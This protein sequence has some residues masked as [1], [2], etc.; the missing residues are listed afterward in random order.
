M[1]PSAAHLAKH[2]P[3]VPCQ[4]D[5][6]ALDGTLYRGVGPGMPRGQARALLTGDRFVGLE[7][8]TFREAQARWLDCLV[9][10]LGAIEPLSMHEATLDL[11]GH[12]RPEEIVLQVLRSVG[13]VEPRIQSSVAGSAWP[14]A[15]LSIIEGMLGTIRRFRSLHFICPVFDGSASQLH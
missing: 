6:E 8:D 11:S 4:E 14:S 10:Y 5:I 3:G 1:I 15:S 13:E 2:W 12:P 9:P 7:R